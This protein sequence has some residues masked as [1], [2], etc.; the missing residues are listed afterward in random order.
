MYG[1]DGPG[2]AAVGV[3]FVGCGTAEGEG[4]G[5]NETENCE[6]NGVDTDCEVLALK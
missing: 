6:E 1:E 3:T 4:Q 5:Y 2:F